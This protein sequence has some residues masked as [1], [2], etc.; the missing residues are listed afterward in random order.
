MPIR[1]IAEV[2]RI[3]AT[4]AMALIGIV[5]SISVPTEN[6]AATK[7][8]PQISNVIPSRNAPTRSILF[9]GFHFPDIKPGNKTLLN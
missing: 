8:N 2:I 4:T 9:L 6:E 7:T 1:I 3:D 5:A